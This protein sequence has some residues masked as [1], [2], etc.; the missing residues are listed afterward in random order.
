ML[1]VRKRDGSL[2]PLDVNTIHSHCELACQGL[3]GVNM[4]ELETD[5]HIQFY[6]GMPTSEI[7]QTL[8]MTAADKTKLHYNWSYVAARLLLLGLYKDVTGGKLDYPDLKEYVTKAVTAGELSPVLLNTGFDFDRLNAAI[9]PERDYR[10]TYLGLVTLHDRYFRR[11]SAGHY[12]RVDAVLELPQHFWMRVAMG[13]CVNGAERPEEVTDRAIEFYEVLS[14]FEFVNSTPTLFNA[15][16]NSPQLS[17]CYLLSM[18]DSLD[19][20]MGTWTEAAGYSKLSGG[21]GVDMSHIR[22]H[23]SFIRG[24]AGKSSGVIPFAKIGEDTLRA[25]NQMGKRKGA[26]CLYLADWHVDVLEFLELKKEAGDPRVRTPDL[27]TAI[28]GSELLLERKNQDGVWSLFCPDE[29]PELT[30]LYGEEFKRAYEA[31]EKRG[32]ARK[33]IDAKVLWRTLMTEKFDT[34]SYFLANK[35]MINRRRMQ[36]GSG[37][38]RSSNLCTEITLNTEPN[39]V[40]AVCNIGSINIVAATKSVRSI[41]QIVRTA[42]RM[43]DNVV[44]IGEVPHKNGRKFQSRER[45]VGLGTMG[46][47]EWLVANG[48]MYGSPT[49]YVMIADLWKEISFSAIEASADL[50]RERGAYELFDKSEWAKGKLPYD[51]AP[52]EALDLLPGYDWSYGE[53]DAYLREKVRGGM[54]NSHTMAIAPTA[55][56]SNIV[57]TTPCQEPTFKLNFVEETLSGNVE[58]ASPILKYNRPDLYI[59]AREIDQERLI[60]AGGIR[61]V[62]IDQAQS[63]NLFLPEGMVYPDGRKV[64]GGVLSRWFEKA[65]KLLKTTYYLRGVST[66]SKQKTKEEEKVMDAMACSID[67]P[68]ACQACQ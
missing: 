19:G 1:N 40:S 27:Q 48:V 58:T 2:V 5:S 47:A 11:D 32:L 46:E 7:T 56:I 53:R 64:T 8:I 50:A 3:D 35:D 31:A 26:G 68:D 30:Y 52:Q 51:T 45:A 23:G 33:T 15:G 17:S 39:D 63:L 61:Q 25:F 21:I 41:G 29:V 49:H 9:R 18:G 59:T 57:G 20:I 24:T 12:G 22:G 54:R 43:L 60:E 13:L 6:N 36:T 44:T 67:N 14:N 28:W 38:V 34:G 66:S 16:T 42:M 37:I 4:S 62:W 65:M 55:T 10:F